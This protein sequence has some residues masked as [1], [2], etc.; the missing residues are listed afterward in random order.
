MNWIDY[1]EVLGL[2]F[3]DTKKKAAFSNRV[4]LLINSLCEKPLYVH[5]DIC[6][7]Y[8]G[9][10]CE[11]PNN[12]YSAIN[13]YSLT[14]VQISIQKETTL[15]GMISKVVAFGHAWNNSFKKNLGN[16]IEQWLYETLDYLKIPYEIMED[17]DGKFVFPKGAKEL[18]EANVN[19]PF[20]WLK[21]Y[22]KARTAMST[23][24]KAYAESADYSNTAD[25]FRKALETFSQEFFNKSSNLENFK[26]DYGKYLK[27]KG[28]PTE[29]S[30][31]FET[32]LQMYTRYMNNYAKHRN[33]TEKKFLE[34][35]T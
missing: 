17:E 25:L 1:R 12:S 34:F 2:G 20:E 4:A 10:V 8:F 23:A 33:R 21:D 3:S 28:V 16:P 22:P 11:C 32:T 26:S 24:L 19:I 35:K 31:N 18:D 15:A 30:E 6:R 27:Q 9:I 5:I 13:G 7:D 29:L 14:N